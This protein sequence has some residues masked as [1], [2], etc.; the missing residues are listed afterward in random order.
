MYRVVANVTENSD[1]NKIALSI[2][3]KYEGL[4]TAISSRKPNKSPVTD[5]NTADTRNDALTLL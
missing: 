4:F 2:R 3:E 5:D 1:V